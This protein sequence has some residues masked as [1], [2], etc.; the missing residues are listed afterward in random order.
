MA[1]ARSCRGSVRNSRVQRESIGRSKTPGATRFRTAASP[2]TRMRTS[3][4]LTSVFMR[5]GSSCPLRPAPPQSPYQANQESQRPGNEDAEERSLIGTRREDDRSNEAE[6]KGD[7]P[8]GHG[9]AEC[10][11]HERAVAAGTR[12]SQP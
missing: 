7:E 6:G 2:R 4:A 8:D 11:I 3:C 10:P 5:S 1:T 12:I 9:R